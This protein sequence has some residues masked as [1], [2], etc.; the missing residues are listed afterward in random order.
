[1]QNWN[2]FYCNKTFVKSHVVEKVF[3]DDAHNLFGYVVRTNEDIVISFR[4]TQGPSLQNWITNLNFLKTDY[5]FAPCNCRVHSGFYDGYMYLKDQIVPVVKSL[6]AKYPSLPIR[7]TGHSLGAALATL[8]VADLAGV[9]GIHVDMMIHFG[10]PRV[11]DDDFVSWFK[12]LGV[13]LSHRVTHYRDIVPHLPPHDFGFSHVPTE[14]WFTTYTNF[15]QCDGSG[16]DPSCSDSV[17]G[18]SIDDHLTYLGI[19]LRNGGAN[20]C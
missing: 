18:D 10:E 3:S 11:G 9:E 14:I 17:I 12:G 4:G 1:L 8:C 13:T 5:Y 6:R 16:E 15:K 20:G 2:C 7:V 19:D